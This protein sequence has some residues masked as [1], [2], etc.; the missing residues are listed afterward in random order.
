MG[1]NTTRSA[2]TTC[3]RAP[4]EAASLLSPAAAEN[5]LR[6]ALG[7]KRAIRPSEEARACAQFLLLGALTIALDPRV[8]DEILADG[9]AL[10]ES[11]I[12]SGR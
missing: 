7:D 1:I 3:S 10:A 9:R 8:L 11:A 4:T 2:M 12:A 5:Q 6:E